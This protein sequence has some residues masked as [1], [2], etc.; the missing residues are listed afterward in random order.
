MVALWELIFDF[1]EISNANFS[2]ILL[3]KQMKLSILVDDLLHHIDTKLCFLLAQE[4]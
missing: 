4:D 2:A 1:S 3:D